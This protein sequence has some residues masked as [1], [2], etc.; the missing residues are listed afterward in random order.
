MMRE[1]K[2]Q[3]FSV[4]A[5]QAFET[6]VQEEE[7]KLLVKKAFKALKSPTSTSSHKG[8]R[9][10]VVDR[11]LT[12]AIAVKPQESLLQEFVAHFI[13]VEPAIK[14]QRR[15]KLDMNT[16]S[17]NIVDSHANGMI[18]GPNGVE[19]RSDVWLGLTL[20]A[21]H[22]RYPDHNHPPAE[23]YLNLSAGEFRHGDSGWFAPGMGGSFY[24]VP[25]TIHA[26]RSNE[27]PLFAFW[28]LYNEN[29]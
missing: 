21:P 7:A 19:E 2:L 10:P 13:A 26:M 23:V 4:V 3:T 16:A 18:F 28:L 5:E 9:L 22:T 11:W 1:E 20:L 15:E 29:M 12:D 17:A 6:Y 27:A 8:E 24:N 14:W 25:F